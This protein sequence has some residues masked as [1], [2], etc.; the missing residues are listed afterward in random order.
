MPLGALF[1]VFLELVLCW[2]WPLLVVAAGI[3]YVREKLAWF[4]GMEI[5]KPP[6]ERTRD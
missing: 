4:F 3:V 6:S 5:W 2:I 1:E